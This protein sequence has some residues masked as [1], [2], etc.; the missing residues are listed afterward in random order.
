MSFNT[1]LYTCIIDWKNQP[2]IGKGN[3]RIWWPFPE[4][5]PPAQWHKNWRSSA[6]RDRIRTPDPL[7]HSIP[8]DLATWQ[9][10]ANLPQ[11]GLWLIKE[12]KHWPKIWSLID[13]RP[14]LPLSRMSWLRKPPPGLR[15]TLAKSL[16]SPSRAVPATRAWSVRSKSKSLSRNLNPRESTRLI[17]LLFLSLPPKNDLKSDSMTEKRRPAEALKRSWGNFDKAHSRSNRTDWPFF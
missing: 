14:P 16:S 1:I 2:T 10:E 9:H 4:R 8:L 17:L 3:W 6:P 13:S 12:K 5:T 11:W 15:Q 7:N